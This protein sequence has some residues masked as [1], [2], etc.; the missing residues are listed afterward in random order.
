M[1]FS[2]TAP[3]HM[4]PVTEGN[5]SELTVMQSHGVSTPARISALSV[6]AE[7]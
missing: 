5:A 1:L 6:M 2:K 7:R 4:E 3:K